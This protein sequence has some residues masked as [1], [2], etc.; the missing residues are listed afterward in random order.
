M[1]ARRLALIVERERLLARSASLRARLV[2][3]SKALTP[4]L[5]L[6]DRLR[7]G[8]HWLRAHPVLVAA[9]VVAVVAVRPR[10]AWRWSLRA[11]SVWQF[12]RRLH[13]R[14]IQL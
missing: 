13:S 2:D 14:L 10:W 9:A 4:V 6:A 8:V 11:W 3:Q 5:N 12:A 7:D 1:S